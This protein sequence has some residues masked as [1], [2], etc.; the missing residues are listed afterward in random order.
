MATKQV[1]GLYKPLMAQILHYG[2]GS[3]EKHLIDTLPSK[4]SKA[5]II[6][7]SSLATKTDLIKQVEKL[8]GG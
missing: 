4:T 6:T 7:G 5:F 2:S 3:V 8:L 1:E